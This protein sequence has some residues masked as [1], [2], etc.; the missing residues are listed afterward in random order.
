MH[1]T[2]A[3]VTA[4]AALTLAGLVDGHGAVVN[5]PPRNAVDKDLAPW[6]GPPPCHVT[7]KCPSVE[8]K[9]GLLVPVGRM[10]PHGVELGGDRVVTAIWPRSKD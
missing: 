4:V 8:T 1:L 7:G 6:N 2:T 3:V 10:A 9:T 5:P